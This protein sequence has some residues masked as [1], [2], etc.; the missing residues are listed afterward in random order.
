MLGSSLLL[1]NIVNGFNGLLFV[2]LLMG[3]FY[4]VSQPGGSKVILKW[5][6]KENRGLAMGIRQAGIPIGGA[7]AG[8]LIPF[9]TIQYNVT[10]AINSIACIC[11]IGGLLFLC[12]IKSHMYRRK[13]GKNI[14]KFLLDAAK[15][16]DM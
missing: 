1:T 15:S 13:Q 10:Y 9:L 16:S 6:P 7:L 3:M 12:F 11:I 4:S 2:L 14:L 8:V 5:F